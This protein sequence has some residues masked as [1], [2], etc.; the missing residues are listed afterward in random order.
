M[1]YITN[2]YD[3]RLYEEKWDY[4]LAIVRFSKKPARESEIQVTALSPST[5]L[6]GWVNDMKEQGKWSELLFN[7]VYVPSFLKEMQEPSARKALNRLYALDKEGK[8]IALTCF[9]KEEELCHR[10][11]VGGLLKGVGCNVVMAS[12]NDY[13]K[14]FEM[15]AEKKEKLTRVKIGK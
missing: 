5:G 14:Y 6:L 9:C 10:S 15:Y 7:L 3:K 12:G 2:R 1:I 13:S 11:I 8:K 4:D